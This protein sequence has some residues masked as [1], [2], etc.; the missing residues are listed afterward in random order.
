MIRPAH[1]SDVPIIAELIRQLARYERL[2]HEVVGTEDDL[3]RHL[4]GER[5]FAE[6]RLAEDAG[7]TVGFAL[8]FHNYSTFLARPG[9]YLEDLFVLPEYR[10]R[11][12]GRALLSAVARLA[13]ERGC[14]RFEW[15]VLDWNEPAI[16]FYRALGATVMDPWRIL[17][18]TGRALTDLAALDGAVSASEPRASRAPPGRE[19]R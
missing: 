14:G 17:R 12:F 18:T 16:A 8:F 9:I 2:E 6:V 10:R 3:R 5:A 15:S 4:F 13:V 7:R 19:G 11:G 1:P